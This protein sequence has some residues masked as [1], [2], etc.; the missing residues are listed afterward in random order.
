VGEEKRR[1]LIVDE[2]PLRRLAIDRQL[3]VL[4][5]EGFGARNGTEGLRMLERGPRFEA[6]FIE[7]QVSDVNVRELAHAAA[8]RAPHLVIWF[9]S[10]RAE[11]VPTL[12]PLLLTPL[13]IDA[14]ALA[15]NISLP[16]WRGSSTSRSR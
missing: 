13:S 14:L 6:M 12:E 2:D 16:P 3:E 4:G 10:S 9:M 7:V 11:R 5:W 15:L 8:L 1:V